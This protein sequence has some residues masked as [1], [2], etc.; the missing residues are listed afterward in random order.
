MENFC[1]DKVTTAWVFVLLLQRPDPK[2]GHEGANVELV[3]CS[4]CLKLAESGAE[5]PWCGSVG[6]GG[7]S[8][9][10]SGSRSGSIAATAE[11][12]DGFPYYYKVWPYL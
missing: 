5:L 6:G 12:R 7:S 3:F 8:S 2:G 4:G 1:G 11:S 10:Q 9:G